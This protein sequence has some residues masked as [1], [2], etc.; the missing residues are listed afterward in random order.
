MCLYEAL[1]G[2]RLFVG[3]LSTPPDVIY[4]QPILPPSKKRPGLNQALDVVMARALAPRPGDRYQSATS[5]TEALRQ[6]AHRC[7]LMYSAPQLAEHLQSILGPDPSRWLQEDTTKTSSDGGTQKIPAKDLQ[8]KEAASIGVVEGSNSDVVSPSRPNEPPRPR[9]GD[10]QP[11][12]DERPGGRAATVAAP[13]P[14][15]KPPTSARDPFIPIHEDDED[16][17][18]VAR[19]RGFVAPPPPAALAPGAPPH[20]LPS[21]A[22]YASLNP[23]SIKRPT[24]KRPTS[25]PPPPRAAL[26]P[27]AP[28]APPSLAAATPMLPS[29]TLLGLGGSPFDPDMP[30]PPPPTNEL[31]APPPTLFSAG[32]PR[33]VRT[34]AAPGA[35]WALSDG[36][37]APAAGPSFGAARSQPPALDLQAPDTI[38]FEAQGPPIRARRSGPPGL[39]VL[40]TLLGAMAGGAKLAQ[41]VTRG[42]VAALEPPGPSAQAK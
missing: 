28:P 35:A 15:A 30:T 3:D 41:V 1:T 42:D 23:P 7:G 14:A 34:V 39:L 4:G 29:T 6:V 13:L 8:G 38:D 24:S 16:A 22:P 17:P 18:T 33:G 2:E 27:P 40:V 12:R 9:R 31:G 21:T 11:G 36:R 25:P 19:D 32:S 5:F 10:D 20:R 37:F 26:V